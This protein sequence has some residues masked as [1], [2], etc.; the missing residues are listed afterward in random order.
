MTGLPPRQSATP[1]EL[2]LRFNAGGYWERARAGEFR[3]VT[4]RS[5][6][7]PPEAGQPPG[8]LSQIVH[9]YTARDEKVAVVH[10]YLLPDGT[11][12]ASGLPDPQMLLE[13]GVLYFVVK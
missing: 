4:K 6:P 3:Q 2:R 12:G 13:G 11:L 10:Q 7:A 1:E 9:Y 8:T 5:R